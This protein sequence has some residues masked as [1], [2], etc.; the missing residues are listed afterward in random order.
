M[1]ETVSRVLGEGK[2]TMSN[3]MPWLRLYSEIAS[4]KKITRICVKTKQP[5]ALVLGVITMLLCIANESPE[6]GKLLISKDM[7]CT[8]DELLFECGLGE[9]GKAIIEA[10]VE[11]NILTLENG[12]YALVNWEK[13]QAPSGDSTERTRRYRERKGSKKQASNVTETSQERHSDDVVASQERIDI[14]ED[15]ESPLTP[16]NGGDEEGGKKIDPVKHALGYNG[17]LNP[18]AT[19]PDDDLEHHFGKYRDEALRIAERE[20][21]PLNQGRRYEIIELAR[22]PDFNLEIFEEYTHEY[23]IN[24]GNPY[25]IADFCRGYPIYKSTGDI[26]AAISGE[27]QENSGEVWV[28]PDTGIEVRW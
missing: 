26:V 27:Q 13:R 28:D 18:T 4:D 20:M 12:T 9:E 10:F 15:I 14:E 23:N 22:A 16:Q 3:A 6:R 24:G 19:Q 1:G 7:P 25:K 11:L 2:I 8:L 17:K 21:G 5:K